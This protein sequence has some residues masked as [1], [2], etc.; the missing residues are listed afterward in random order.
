M[1]RCLYCNECQSEFF[2]SG[3]KPEDCAMRES[4]SK[5]KED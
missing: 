2:E 1:K 4:V 5:R 3:H